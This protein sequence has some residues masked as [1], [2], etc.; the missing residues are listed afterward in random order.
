MTYPFPYLLLLAAI[1]AACT[2]PAKSSSQVEPRPTIVLT[3]THGTIVL[4]LYNETP[5]HRDNF[6]QLI[7]DA[8]LDSLLFHRVIDEFLI[9]TGDPNSKTAPP[10][11]T[12]GN[13]DLPYQVEAEFHPDL[14]H[15]RGALNAA[16]DG[17]PARASSSTQFCIIQR[18]PRNDSLIEIDQGRINGWLAEHAMQQDSLHL[19]LF[20]ARDQ[21]IY[22]QDWE[23]Y[24]RYAD[25][26]TTLAASY[27]SYEP[28]TIPEAHREVYR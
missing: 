9:Q 1:L 18:G 7:E 14:F 11:D 27:T 8:T 25:S 5:K 12:L 28:Y 17:N 19:P 22:D 2:Q 10:D 6:L 26:L 4:E 16:R 15:K 13:G 20:K 21:A 3:T 24:H 23:E